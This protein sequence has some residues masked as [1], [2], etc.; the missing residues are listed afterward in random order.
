M[1]SKLLRQAIAVAKKIPLDFGQYEVRRT[2][3]GKAILL[4]LL[5]DGRGKK[6]LDLGCREQYWS[7]KIADRGYAVVSVDLEPQSPS[8][9]RVDADDPLPFP[10]EEF[11]LVWCSEVIEHVK[12]PAFTLGE[13]RRVLKPGGSLLLTTPNSKFWVFRMFRLLGASPAALQ[14]EDHKQFFS[15]ADMRGLFSGDY[16]L[17]GYFPYLL[18]KRTLTRGFSL[19]S[20]TIVVHYRRERS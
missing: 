17:F 7:K 8:V 9:L 4:S 15:Y 18:Y 11:D 13:I 14:N 10:A 2:T 1:R 5:E 6:A 3:K 12:D 20:P 16:H 19:L